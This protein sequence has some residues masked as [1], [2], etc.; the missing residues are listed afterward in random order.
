MSCR[1]LEALTTSVSFLRPH[2]KSSDSSE[3]P[4]R[5]APFCRGARHISVMTKLKQKRWW[6]GKR[7]PTPT[8]G[9]GKGVVV[10]NS[11]SAQLLESRAS[12]HGS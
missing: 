2:S 1:F 11:G 5:P 9:G 8:G 4:P 7:F 12:D 3:H 10:S 6:L